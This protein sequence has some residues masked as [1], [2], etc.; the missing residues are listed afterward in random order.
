MQDP[1]QHKNDRDEPD[2]GGGAQGGHEL[3]KILHRYRG[4]KARLDWAAGGGVT[5][6]K[7]WL[8]RTDYG[9]MTQIR[10]DVWT[11]RVL[12]AVW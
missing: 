1:S 8:L 10:E 12:L 9:H 11:E 3:P 5:A 6:T 7:R 4:E 2:G